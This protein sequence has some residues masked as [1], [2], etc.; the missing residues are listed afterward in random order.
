MRQLHRRFLPVLTLSPV[1]RRRAVGCAGSRCSGSR[2]ADVLH[3]RPRLLADRQRHLPPPPLPVA[4]DVR[5]VPLEFGNDLNDLTDLRAARHHT[6]RQRCC[7]VCLGS[8]ASARGEVR[9]VAAALPR[10]CSDQAPLGVELQQQPAVVERVFSA[11]ELSVKVCEG[12]GPLL[13]HTQGWE[14]EARG[15]D[16]STR[17]MSGGCR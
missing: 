15:R 12:G 1:R 11:S 17:R 2:V 14:T 3:G 5:Y 4:L 16:D 9:P 13:R 8:L 7:L 10:L 6:A